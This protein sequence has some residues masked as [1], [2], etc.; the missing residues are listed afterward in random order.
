MYGFRQRSI[1]RLLRFVFGRDVFISYSRED[2]LEYARRLAVLLGERKGLSVYLDQW[3]STIGRRL[4]LRLRLALRRSGMFVLVATPAALRSRYVRRELVKFALTRRTI[5][6]VD[7][8]GALAEAIEKKQTSPLLT[9]VL[10]R[11]ERI[12]DHPEPSEEILDAIANA[13]TFTRQERRTSSTVVTGLATAVLALTVAG[14]VSWLV[15]RASREDAAARVADA[16]RQVA[17]AQAEER[18][19]KKAERQATERAQRQAAIA[20]ALSLAN[21]SGNVMAQQPDDITRA[22]LLAVEASARMKQLGLRSLQTDTA[23]R[24]VAALVPRVSFSAPLHGTDADLLRM[25]RDGRI[26]V[27]V[28]KS[29]IEIQDTVREKRFTIREVG[30]ITLSSDGSHLV[31]AQREGDATRLQVYGIAAA[32][33]LLRTFEEP[34]HVYALT[35]SHDGTWLATRGVHGL[36]VWNTRTGERHADRTPCD[37][38]LLDFVF[39]PDG[40]RLGV[41]CADVVR[42]WDWQADTRSEIMRPPAPQDGQVIAFTPDGEFVAVL[43]TTGSGIWPVAG[44][45]P[46][47]P[48]ANRGHSRGPFFGDGVHVAFSTAEFIDMFSLY[49]ATDSFRIQSPCDGPLAFDAMATLVVVG[50]PGNSVHVYDT[51]SRRELARLRIEGRPS[52]TRPPAVAFADGIMTAITPQAV[53]RWRLDLAEPAWQSPNT[54]RTIA[55]SPDGKRIATIDLR[56][57]DRVVVLTPHT[58]QERFLYLSGASALAYTSS[59]RLLVAHGAGV[60][61]VTGNG[62]ADLPLGKE[63]ANSTLLAA[64]PRADRFAFVRG[65]DVYV[66]EGASA[67]RTARLQHPAEIAAL[68]LSGE[69]IVTA[70]H[71]GVVRRW[72]GDG[73]RAGEYRFGGDVSTV[74]VSRDG[75]FIAAANFRSPAVRVWDTRTGR[76]RTLT[77]EAGVSGLAFDPSGL[78]LATVTEANTLHVWEHTTDTPQQVVRIAGSDTRDVAFSPDG[79]WLAHGQPIRLVEWQ[80]GRLEAAVCARLERKALTRDEWTRHLP[81]EPYRITCVERAVQ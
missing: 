79:R 15:A 35:L 45:E 20:A 69:E 49:R 81:N 13:V 80:P 65:A 40:R 56:Q 71:D 23:L 72:T 77:H 22:A 29:S 2:G 59:G 44:G 64:A 37:S 67:R 8:D 10:R 58:S 32:P 47:V 42:L 24:R 1:D 30:G 39:H 48:F 38:Y 62:L 76:A 60:S 63:A 14:A 55:F 52:L 68:A 27:A 61:V 73:S 17:S 31:V 41:S 70:S 9:H 75:A 74:T 46:V 11:R 3:A 34:H 25:T 66:H 7:A 43:G 4:P 5:F 6:A 36:A 28:G 12:E 57:I 50:C 18:Q 21:D 19:A 51:I 16:D 78:F 53:K 54:G 26:V 33:E